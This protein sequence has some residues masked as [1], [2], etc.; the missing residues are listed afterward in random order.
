MT[1]SIFVLSG[2]E[3]K[4]KLRLD[5][6]VAQL[7]ADSGNALQA[8]IDEFEKKAQAKSNNPDE[9]DGVLT[10]EHLVDFEHL[11]IKDQFE[12][13]E[14]DDEVMKAN[15]KDLSPSE[16]KRIKDKQRK[17]ILVKRQKQ[18]QQRLHQHKKVREEGQPFQVTAKAPQDGWYRV[19]VDGAFYQVR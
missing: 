17:K 15:H 5:G 19:C 4:A 13:E 8:S 2:Q 3:L 9:A 10:Q 14:S 16:R 7:D 18:E 12:E 6:P 11:N 1:A